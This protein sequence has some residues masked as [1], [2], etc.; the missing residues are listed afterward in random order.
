MDIKNLDIEVGTKI[1]CNEGHVWLFC[2]KA[3]QSTGSIYYHFIRPS[4]VYLARGMWT[5]RA[6]S[7]KTL[8]KKFPTIEQYLKE[9]T[10]EEFCYK[11]N[12]RLAG[13]ED[14]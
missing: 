13:K 7:Y 4:T 3:I 6:C 5:Y 9:E 12:I 1:N 2:Q 14:K 11:I 10:D 8:L